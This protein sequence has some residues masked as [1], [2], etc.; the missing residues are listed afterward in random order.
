MSV[1]R[2]VQAIR[3]SLVSIAHALARLAPVLE[4]AVG[5]ISKES[6][7]GRKLRL[8]PARRSALKLQGQYMGVDLLE[9][10][11]RELP[12]IVLV[13]VEAPPTPGKVSALREAEGLVVFGGL[14]GNF[15]TRRAGPRRRRHHA[16]KRHDRRIRP[17]TGALREG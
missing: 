10:M 3:R 17:H 13:K 8:S 15:L 16:R 5:G 6:I 12:R 4:A 9:R 14:N 11:H 2:D 7:R 1:G